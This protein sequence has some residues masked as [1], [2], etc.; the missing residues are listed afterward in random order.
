LDPLGPI[1][2]AE[3]DKPGRQ[4]M[5]IE[6]RDKRFG[7]IIDPSAELEIVARGF[8]FTEGPVWLSEQ[9]KLVFSDIPGDQMHVWSA[10]DGVSSYRKPSH[11]ANGN[12]R[13]RK[14][15]LLTC[16]HATSMVSREELDGTR[17]VLAARY[18]GSEL[19]SPNDIIER[20]DGTLF[21]TDPTYG[22]VAEYGIE[23][24]QE[25]PFRGVYRVDEDGRNLTLLAD[26]F[27]Q[28][29]GLCFSLDGRK[30]YI[31]DSERLH[32]RLFDLSAEGDLSNGK[33]FAE[34]VGEGLGS[35]DGL[36]ID[37]K[38]N[39][40]CAS[41]GGIHVFDPEGRCL[42]VIRVPEE[43][44]NFGFGGDDRRT[45]FVTASTSVYRIPLK[46]PGI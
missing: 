12:F 27:V 40:F 32:I 30:I 35:P 24:P 31:N 38:G 11:M 41:Q 6:V 5:P 13:D 42:G 45:L 36:K 10:K 29:N 7:D 15:R 43:T 21:F 3:G 16:E 46:Q 4:A 20:A 34:T 1:Q 25:L 26:D 14:G 44:A 19:N 9:R 17:T 39:V 37:R 22:R 8:R 23:R 28:P 33:V 2:T 18:R